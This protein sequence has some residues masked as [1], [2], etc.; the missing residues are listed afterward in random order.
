[1]ITSRESRLAQ[2]PART[3]IVAWKTCGAV[4]SLRISFCAVTLKRTKPPG[5]TL[6]KP[7]PSGRITGGL[8]NGGGGGGSASSGTMSLMKSAL[9]EGGGS[10][11]PFSP[12]VWPTTWDDSIKIAR[13]LSKL[14]GRKV[15]DPATR[16]WNL[17]NALY[18]KAGYVP[19]RLPREPSALATSFIALLIAVMHTL[20]RLATDSE[21]I[22]INAAGLS[23]GRFVRP[24][25][26][27]TCVVSLLV[28]FLSLYLAPEC[29]RALRRWQTE[30]GADSGALREYARAVEAIRN[31]AQTGRIGDGKIFVL[32][33]LAVTRIRT[34]E[35]GA[36]AL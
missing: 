12:M 31:A 33:L 19:W 15:Q 2:P 36:S 3:R 27:A 9:V 5:T 8:K 34:G 28:A 23:P 21:I 11:S 29:M 22:V 30:I 35:T 26:Y 16:A 20:N 7:L 17:F 24:F 32:D 25:L 6:E 13:K 10:T 18:Y 14:S 1:M 4:V